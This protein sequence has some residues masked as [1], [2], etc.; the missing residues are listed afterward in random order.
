MKTI[1]SFNNLKKI[2]TRWSVKMSKL[3][4]EKYVWIIKFVKD[5]ESDF[6]YKYRTKKIKVSLNN[7]QSI[8]NKELNG[9]I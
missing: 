4:L 3:V 5:W 2:N 9:I 6:I 7:D 8:I 1:R